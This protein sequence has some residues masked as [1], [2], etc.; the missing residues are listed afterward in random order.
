LPKTVEGFGGKDPENRETF[1]KYPHFVI[2]AKAGIQK[3]LK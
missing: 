1:E 3:V 2:P